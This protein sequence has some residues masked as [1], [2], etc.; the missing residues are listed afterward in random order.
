VPKSIVATIAAAALLCLAL[1][2]L[3]ARG[4]TE[5]AEKVMQRN[6]TANKLKTVKNSVAMTLTSERGGVRERKL[7]LV[8]KLQPNGVDYNLAISFIYPPDIK[9]TGFLQIEHPNEDDLWI[10]LPALQK[11][12][13]LV[14]KDKK[15]S[16]FGSDFS[17]GDMLQPRVELYRHKL[18][19]SETVDGHPCH[20]IESVPRN[21]TEAANSG[22]AR[23]LLWIRKDNFMECRIQYFDAGGA[24]LKTQTVTEHKQVD[25]GGNGWLALRREMVNHRTQH[26]TQLVFSNVLV[27]QAIPDRFFTTRTLEKAWQR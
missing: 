13:R 2:A 15:D 10:Y 18:V 6:F 21:E 19:G 26:K 22:Y 16:F 3:P 4:A 14:S 20:L 5:S 25:P 24:L 11:S 9:G 23:K 17:Y 1:L 12:R 27:G 7:D 8:G